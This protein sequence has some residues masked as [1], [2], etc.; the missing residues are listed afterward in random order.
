[1]TILS[2]D[3]FLIDLGMNF[4]PCDSLEIHAPK[5]RLRNAPERQVVHCPESRCRKTHT[6]KIPLWS[7]FSPLPRFQQFPYVSHSL[8]QL[9]N[10]GIV[11]M[12]GAVDAAA[13][14]IDVRGNT[15]DGSSQLFLFCVIDLDDV[16]VNQ[17]FPGVCAEIAST[18]LIHLVANYA[19]FLLVQADFLADGSCAVWHIET[20]LSQYNGHFFS[21][22]L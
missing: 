18:K 8:F 21:K 5:I 6:W 22:T 20:L 16:P 9:G 12:P 7:K 1:M 4:I 15:A 13:N 19:Q 2:V 11:K 3:L 10:I 14:L 17:H